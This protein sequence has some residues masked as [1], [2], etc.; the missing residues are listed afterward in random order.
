MYEEDGKM[1]P[2]QIWSVCGDPGYRM[3]ACLLLLQ[4]PL[5]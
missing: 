5:G 3:I 1:L 4:K 2:S